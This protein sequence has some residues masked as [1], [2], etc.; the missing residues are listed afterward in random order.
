MKRIY[1]LIFLICLVGIGLHAQISLKFAPEQMRVN[2]LRTMSFDPVVPQSQPLLT[3]LTVTN[4]G[5]PELVNLQIALSWNNQYII[6]PGEAKFI[7]KTKMQTNESVALT[8]RD[9]IN[10]NGSERFRTDGS[11]NI[12]I[13]DV[14]TELSNLKDAVMAGSFPDGVLTLEVSAKPESSDKWQRK[15]FVITVRNINSI[16]L[17]SPGKAIGQLP[18][19]VQD[20]PVSFFWQT[21]KT[22]FNT[23]EHLRI[24]EFPPNR[25]PNLTNVENMGRLVFDNQTD[26]GFNNFLP[27]N[28]GYYYAWQVYLPLYDIHNPNTAGRPEDP[29]TLLKS[30]WNVFRYVAN[31]ADSNDLDEFQAALNMLNNR[32]VDKARND[33]WTP[34]GEIILNG[35]AVRS[36]E[37][38]DAITDLIGKE[39]DAE[40]MP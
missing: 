29:R 35:R 23:E 40:V 34:L 22:D 25:Q 24:Y 13:F 12:D 36:M 10:Q 21:Q 38:I 18:P 3:T 2:E 28:D 26:S 5:E 11:I 37:A 31:V 17:L 7:S 19:Q 39:I 9:L 16:T 14:L 1:L 6:H 20:L 33:G 4:L 15:N 32:V 8:N 30:G 27:F